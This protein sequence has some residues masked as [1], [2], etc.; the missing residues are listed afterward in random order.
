MVAK[1]LFVESGLC[2][3]IFYNIGVK[4]TISRLRIAQKNKMSICKWNFANKE[5][6]K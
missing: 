2:Y 6:V 3:F 4:I 5:R 1:Y